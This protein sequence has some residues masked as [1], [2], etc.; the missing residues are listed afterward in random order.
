MSPSN[1]VNKMVKV[2]A[3]TGNTL[4]PGNLGTP[5]GARHESTDL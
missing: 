1:I 2:F 3:N 4:L 5:L